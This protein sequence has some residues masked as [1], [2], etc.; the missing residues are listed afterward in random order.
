MQSRSGKD[1]ASQCFINFNVHTKQ[2]EVHENADSDSDGW[3]KAYNSTPLKRS[4]VL[5]MLLACGPQSE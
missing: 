5:A 2:L 4:Y 1:S 3:G